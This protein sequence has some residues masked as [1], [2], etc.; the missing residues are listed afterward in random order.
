[1]RVAIYARVSTEDQQTDTQIQLCRDNCKRL[2]YEVHKVYVDNAISGAKTSRPSFNQMLDDMRACKFDC[3]MVTKLDRIGR[4]LQHLLSLFNEFNTK[5]VHFVSVTQNIDTISASGRLML[6]IIGAFA[7]Y[8][9]NIISERTKEGL[10]NKI[11]V[12]KRG[13][14]TK[15]RKRRGG[16]KKPTFYD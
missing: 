2:E 9:R 4:S 14:D 10:A 12:G 15:P 7:E 3:I 6:H 5:G 16:L 13:K 1:M 8:E 11:G